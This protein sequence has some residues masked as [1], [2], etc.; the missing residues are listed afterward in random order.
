MVDNLKH[1]RWLLALKQ[2]LD[3]LMIVALL[4]S[5]T[6]LLEN[7]SNVFLSYF[8]L[9]FLKDFLFWLGPINQGIWTLTLPIYSFWFI[10]VWGYFLAL[11]YDNDAVLGSIISVSSYLLAS[12]FLNF[13]FKVTW[14]NLSTQNLFFAFFVSTIFVVVY[15]F[16][17]K[18][19]FQLSIMPGRFT[20]FYKKLSHLTSF[21]VT[22][23]VMFVYFRETPKMLHLTLRDMFNQ[24]QLNVVAMS[25]NFVVILIF[26]LLIQLYCYFNF[27]GYN[28]MLTVTEFIYLTSQNFN[29]E[30][31]NY[32]QLPHYLLTK[33][34]LDSY[35]FIG[36][37]GS[38]LAFVLGVLFFSK[39]PERRRVAKY[40]LAP[41]IFNL[42]SSTLFGIPVILNKRYFIPFMITP[43]ISLITTY[44]AL[45]MKLIEPIQIALP[46]IVPP[47]LN[48][49]LATNL[50]LN[51]LGLIAVNFLISFMIW[52]RYIKRENDLDKTVN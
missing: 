1:L 23:L 11:L 16:M 19:Q 26:L 17:T 15:N 41:G 6:I 9:P 33:S 49:F 48:G 18:L 13:N 29:I 8:H 51:A 40:S 28:L 14:Q 34:T 21:L 38:T 37:V 43:I 31:A 32:H 2:T 4:G 20:W 7:F 52:T 45:S 10:L 27:Q 30:A 42:N 25:Q 12:G 50:D 5:L 35:V 36:G 44:I 22:L 46:T 39:I 47:F 24:L 3:V